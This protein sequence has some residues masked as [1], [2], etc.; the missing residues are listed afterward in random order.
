MG[1]RIAAITILMLSAQALRGEPSVHS[2]DNL[3]QLRAGQRIAV[4]DMKLKTAQGEFAG[5]SENAVSLGVGGNEISIPRE[6]V[7]SVKNREKSHRRRNVLLGLAI[8]AAGG[9]AAASV[10]GATYHEEGETSVFMLVYTP[11][12][13][14]IGA[15]TG[16]V[17]P[18]GDATV[19]RA[20]APAP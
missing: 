1:K 19:Y 20:A 11:I 14:G 2:W 3:R 12:G 15:A 8:G 7:F 16:A 17:L 5:Y 4:T 13:A 10:R 9:L 6:Q 18:T